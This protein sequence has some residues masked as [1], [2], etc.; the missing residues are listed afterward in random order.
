MKKILV[1]LGIC[2]LLL[3]ILTPA[4]IG[5]NAA[6]V[7]PHVFQADGGVPAPPFPSLV[8]IWADGGVPAPPFPSKG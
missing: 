4:V 3:V 1:F 2:A 6:L 7:N 8:T 5:V